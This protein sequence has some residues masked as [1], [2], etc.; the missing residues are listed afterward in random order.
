MSQIQINNAQV[1]LQLAQA[2]P[3]DDLGTENM[4]TM[5]PALQKAVN[6]LKEEKAAEAMKSAA[7]LILKIYD[8]TESKKKELIEQIREARRAE[9]MAKANLA[10]LDRAK[11]YAETSNN[12]LPLASMIGSFVAGCQFI[13]LNKFAIPSSFGVSKKLQNSGYSGVMSN[14]KETK[15]TV[16]STA[17]TRS[18]SK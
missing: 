11:S 8:A 13:D 3:S 18:A 4:S 1:L 2:L 12:Y 7:A 17:K 6:A 15:P 5:P 9:A 10:E 16:S 14:S